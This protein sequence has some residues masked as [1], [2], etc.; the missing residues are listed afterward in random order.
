[1]VWWHSCTHRTWSSSHLQLLF[2]SLNQ[3]TLLVHPGWQLILPPIWTDLLSLFHLGGVINDKHSSNA[4]LY[5]NTGWLLWWMRLSLTLAASVDME[6]NTEIQKR[7]WPRIYQHTKK[8]QVWADVWPCCSSVALCLWK[9]NSAC[10]LLM[11][12]TALQAFEL[13]TISVFSF[14]I[15]ACLFCKRNHI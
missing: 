11:L 15:P 3:T 9:P 4:D 2:M 7:P 1:M 6:C 5:A 12:D 8:R 13:L 10:V 14:P